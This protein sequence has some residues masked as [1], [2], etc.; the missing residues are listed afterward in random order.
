MAK[1]SRVVQ[2]QM[3]LARL[4]FKDSLKALNFMIG[5]MNA[6][7]G[8]KRHDGRHYYYHLVDGAQDL[9]NHGVT[10][11]IVIT[12]YILHD[13]IEDVPDATYE[14]VLALFG[15]E[16]ADTVLG[17]TKNP[18]VNYKKGE[19][20]KAYLDDMLP[21]VRM[22]LVKTA[23][24]KHNFSTLKDATPEKELRQALE[25]EKYFLPFFKEAR[26]RFPEYSRYFHSAKTTI[27]PHLNKIK[28][29]HAF[30]A[31]HERQI[32]EI[33]IY[34][35]DELQSRFLEDGGVTNQAEV[36]LVEEIARNIKHITKGGTLK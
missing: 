33:K 29:H 19:N 34:L 28:E 6:D 24:R 13:Y 25:T 21:F 8:Y 16:V 9:L 26:K 1:E 32:A 5:T 4:E 18:D 30:V 36:E 20:L 12:S 3:D 11:E 35:Y 22:C 14:G 27:M 15:R 10:D 7:N 17:V 2:L 23:D 31:E